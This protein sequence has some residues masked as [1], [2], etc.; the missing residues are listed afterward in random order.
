M[1]ISGGRL[2]Q[3]TI[4]YLFIF[5]FMALISVGL[6]KSMNAVLGKGVGSLGK[7]LS[8]HLS[9]GVCPQWCYYDGFV[10]KPK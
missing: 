2:G 10:N 8:E 9:V 3:A 6:V 4:E 7:V 5:G 1:G